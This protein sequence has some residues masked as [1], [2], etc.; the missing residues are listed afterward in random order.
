VMPLSG[1]HFVWNARSARRSRGCSRLKKTIA[2]QE[3]YTI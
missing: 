2:C 3:K 1:R